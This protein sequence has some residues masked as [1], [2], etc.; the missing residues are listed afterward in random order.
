MELLE[1]VESG[2]A[3]PLVFFAYGQAVHPSHSKDGP[4]KS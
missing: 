3:A 1:L 2:Y 4:D